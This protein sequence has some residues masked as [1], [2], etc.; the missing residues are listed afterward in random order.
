MRGFLPRVL[1]NDNIDL[2]RRLIAV[3]GLLIGANVL[4]W[5]WAVTALHGHLVLLGTALL[6]YVRSAPCRR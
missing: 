1:N 3:Y 2:N 5:V 4:I 6:A